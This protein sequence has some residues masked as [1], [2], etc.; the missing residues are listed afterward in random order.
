[1]I[2]ELITRCFHA[3]TI[4]HIHHL[5]TKSYA[6]HVA[7][8]G[9]Y[10]DIL[11]LVDGIAEAYQGKYGLIDSYPGRYSYVDDSVTLVKGLAEWIEAN[12]YE[13]CDAEDT[14][15]QNMI[16][17]LLALCAGTTYKLRFLK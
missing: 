10:E 2:G 6:T 16:D 3:R 14:C 17:E 11:G 4:A 8:Q 13:C 15:L 7:L 9:F 1:M 5:K 12:R